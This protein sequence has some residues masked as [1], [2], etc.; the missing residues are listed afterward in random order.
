MQQKNNLVPLT[1][2]PQGGFRFAAIDPPWHFASNSSDKP[3]RN[4]LRHYKT[5]RLPEIAALPVGELLAPNSLVGLWIT[6]PLLVTGAHLPIFKSWGVKPNAMG[7]VWI[8]LNPNA[9]SLFILVKDLAMGGGFTTRKNA[10]FCVFGS[11]GRSIRQNAAVH[12]VIVSPR[13]EHSRKPIEF[14]E[15]V[16]KYTDGPYLEMFARQQRKGWTCW[17]NEVGKFA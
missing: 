3:G 16:E 9:A 8:K 2:L 11:R 4:A 1:E 7:F 14:F 13:R 5:M 15:R 10:E 6:G 17:G 12:E